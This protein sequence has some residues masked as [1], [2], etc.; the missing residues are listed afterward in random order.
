MRP[1]RSHAV[2]LPSALSLATAAISRA[3]PD[4]PA[5]AALRETLAAH[6]QLPPELTR[7]AAGLT[8]AYWRWFGWLDAA[9]PLGARVEQAAALAERF[10]QRPESVSNSAL[11]ARAL[12]AWAFEEM[13]IGPASLRSFQAEPT[14]WIRARRGQA[15]ALAAE[16]KSCRPA[17]FPQ[18]PEALAYDGKA[19]LYRSTA[20]G[21]GRLEIQDIAS[22]AVGALCAPQPGETWWDA[23]A[24]EGGKT[25]HLADLMD[26]KGLVWA[27]DRS[28]RRLTTLKR[29]IG[30]T[31]LFNWRSAH[32]EGAGTPPGRARCDGV[33]V[34]APCSGTGTWGRNP[35]ARWTVE[36]KDVA[37]LADAQQKLLSVAAEAVKPGGRLVYAVCSLARSET[38]AV[39]DAFEAAHPQ[40]RPLPARSPFLPAADPAPR[41][42]LLPEEG[43]GNGMFVALWQREG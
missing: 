39:A 8:F 28:E 40:F 30:R 27:T 25:L 12:P 22:Q 21:E 13:E 41:W 37:E 9:W 15:A 11:I 2:R 26:N 38:A 7:L 19:D 14:L 17:G 35:H 24:G 33:L 3:A 34:D 36:P 10:R 42:R 4:F 6:R 20:M 31:K 29:R 5:D 16:L 1:Q 18:L 32:W 23:C 43:G